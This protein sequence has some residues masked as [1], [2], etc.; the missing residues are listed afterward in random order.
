MSLDH[1]SVKRIFI[2]INFFPDPV[3]YDML[4]DIKKRLEKER[5]RWVKTDNL[6]ITLR[7]I[8]DYDINKIPEISEILSDVAL[9]TTGFKLIY[10]DLGVFKSLSYPKVL[11]VGLEQ[12]IALR[13]LKK[14]IDL[15]LNKTGFDFKEKK[16]SPHLTLG[17][18]KYLK[19][20]DSLRELMQNYKNKVFMRQN[21]ESIVLMES[22]IDQKGAEYFP[23]S[24]H[25]F[26]D[27]R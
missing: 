21:V 2:A 9:N 14:K 17:R 18:M 16:F 23:V 6:H 20:K 19:D 24:E 25:F 4:M 7:F 27:D 8:G 1:N 3:F 10:K 5:I 13:E 22:K 26:P 15:E 12:S 11:W